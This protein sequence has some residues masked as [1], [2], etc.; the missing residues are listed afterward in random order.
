MQQRQRLWVA[1]PERKKTPN[2][3]IKHS[4]HKRN[5]NVGNTCL[6]SAVPKLKEAAAAAAFDPLPSSPGSAIPAT[7]SLAEETNPD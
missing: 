1:R 7:F 6:S 2:Y 3:Q 5:K 4:K